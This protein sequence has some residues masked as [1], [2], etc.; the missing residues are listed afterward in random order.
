MRCIMSFERMW[1][2]LAPVGR[3]AGGGY[4]RQPFASAERECHAWFLEEATSRD[5]RVEQDGFGNTI[6]WLGEGAD[7]VLTGSHLDS[8]L[9]GGAYDGPLG[10]VSALAAIDVLRDRGFAPSRPIGISVFTEEEGS[11]FGL[12]C[13]GSRLVTGASTW[14]SARA[15]RDRAVVFLGYAEP[16]A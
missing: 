14:E 2:D 12:A 10:V 15:R 1:H 16:A 9:D 6:A 13:L 7:G 11:R 5:L 4:F 8:V 3:A